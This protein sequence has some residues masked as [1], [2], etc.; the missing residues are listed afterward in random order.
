MQE[1][2]KHREEAAL[3]EL[4]HAAAELEVAFLRTPHGF[5]FVPM[6][7]AEAT[8]SQEEFEQLPKSASRRSPGTSRPCTS[9]C[10]S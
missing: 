10:T 5:A 1:E 8:M 3:H 2:E 6:K 7:S 4:G 9:A